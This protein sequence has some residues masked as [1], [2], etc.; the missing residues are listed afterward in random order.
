[1]K[2][3]LVAGVIVLFLGLAIAPSINANVSKA[4][5]DSELV[6]ITTELCCNNEDYQKENIFIGFILDVEIGKEEGNN[7]SYFYLKYLFTLRLRYSDGELKNSSI[8]K[9]PYGSKIYYKE[10]N[11][12]GY[13]GSFFIC[14]K[15]SYNVF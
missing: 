11:I 9:Y 8:W 14:A 10:A 13:I 2:K 12:K 15:L 3:L 1:M 5:I 6:E 4:S 7:Y